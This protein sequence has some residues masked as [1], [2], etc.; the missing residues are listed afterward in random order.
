[1]FSILPIA[2]SFY[3][4]YF[5]NNELGTNKTTHENTL[6]LSSDSDKNVDSEINKLDERDIQVIS[7]CLDVVS[8]AFSTDKSS[9]AQVLL[10][11]F[12]IS[13]AEG[14]YTECSDESMFDT[15]LHSFINKT[16]RIFKKSTRLAKFLEEKAGNCAERSNF[17]AVLIIQATGTIDSID[18]LEEI[19]GDHVVIRYKSASG[20]TWIID[21]FVLRYYIENEKNIASFRIPHFSNNPQEVKFIETDHYEDKRLCLVYDFLYNES[22]Y[23][24]FDKYFITKDFPYR[25]WQNLGQDL[26]YIDDIDD[27]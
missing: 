24:D 18:R 16:R 11:R 13:L 19:N 27:D 21:P 10:N 17:L 5:K 8:R 1:M 9:T 22:I 7:K 26:F 12:E 23:N 14:L 2:S 6:L 4:T 25:Y 20:K 15:E 3:N